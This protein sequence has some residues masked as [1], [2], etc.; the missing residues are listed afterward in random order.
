MNS[1]MAVAEDGAGKKVV[2]RGEPPESGTLWLQ[3]NDQ[4]VLRY[5]IFS[6]YMNQTCHL[7][8]K[9]LCLFFF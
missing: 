4:S 3:E 6:S 5:H 1:Q 8:S 9:H 2:K 7:K